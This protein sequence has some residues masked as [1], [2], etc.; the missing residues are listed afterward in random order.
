MTNPNIPLE[1]L[2]KFDILLNFLS[3]STLACAPS[4]DS[5]FCAKVSASVAAV[6]ASSASVIA[7]DRSGIS[8]APPMLWLDPCLSGTPPPSPVIVTSPAAGLVVMIIPGPALR[9]NL[10][11]GPV[12][13]TLLTWLKAL[14]SEP[15]LLSLSRSAVVKCLSSSAICVVSCVPDALLFQ[16]VLSAAV[17]WTA[18]FPTWVSTVAL[19]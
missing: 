5:A 17:T 7:L 16:F 19:R 2:N 13:N 15:M 14:M 6:L 1:F 10:L 3:A 9:F 18:A 4:F 8:S 12:A 11:S